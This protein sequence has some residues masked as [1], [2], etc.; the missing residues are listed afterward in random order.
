MKRHRSSHKGTHLIEA[1]LQFRG[2][3]LSSWQ[4]DDSML[5]IVLEK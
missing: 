5:D 4:E 2:L 1:G 3:D